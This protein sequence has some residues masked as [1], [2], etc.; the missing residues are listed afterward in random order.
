MKSQ[1]PCPKIPACSQCYLAPASS[2]AEAIE[3]LTVHCVLVLTTAYSPDSGYLA[4]RRT[5][6]PLRTE[7]TG[8]DA[9]AHIQVLAESLDE[10][11]GTR[12][13]SFPEVARTDVAGLLCRLRQVAQKISRHASCESQEVRAFQRKLEAA[14]ARWPYAWSCYVHE[15]AAV[16]RDR[17]YLLTLCGEALERTPPGPAVVTLRAA[18][19]FACDRIVD[20][21]P[22]NS[23][24]SVARAQKARPSAQLRGAASAGE[25]TALTSAQRR[26]FNYCE[27]LARLHAA[28]I[29]VPH[30][31]VRGRFW[32]LIAAPSGSGKSALVRV[33]ARRLGYQYLRIQRGDMVPLGAKGIPTQFV[34]LNA[35]VSNP[36]RLLVHWDELDKFIVA[37]GS[38]APSQEWSAGIWSCLYSCLDGAFN[39]PAYLAIPANERAARRD[40]SVQV[41]EEYLRRRVQDA[42]QIGS[43]TWQVAFEQASKRRL[44]FGGEQ[45]A[46]CSVTA[47]D[48]MRSR[49]IPAELF[50]RFHSEIQVMNHPGADEVTKLLEATGLKQLAKETGY[51]IR[52]DEIDFTTRGGFRALETLY[53]R[54]LIKKEE[55][56]TAELVGEELPPGTIFP[57]KSLAEK[58]A[59]AKV[60]RTGAEGE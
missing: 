17:S 3:N 16:L 1:R 2:R 11:E 32:P 18:I 33:L 37:D 57:Q 49:Q 52:P 55:Y 13:L 29:D 48:L 42:F 20:N 41:T 21:P 45:T 53:T 39:I 26:V 47:V 23:I 7:A 15:T 60:S 56:K 5:A 27:I 28:S 12:T 35:L 50:L 4:E 59:S 54:I 6:A 19:D 24:A 8:P 34:I 46:S 9:D 58:G 38:A 30:G 36:S 14:L 51:E 25:F 31:P 43:G 10:L 22:E 40:A 44:G